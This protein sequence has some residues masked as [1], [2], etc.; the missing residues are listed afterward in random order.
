MAAR[1]VHSEGLGLKH[2]EGRNPLMSVS[3]S[4]SERASTSP[5]GHDKTTTMC[6]GQVRDTG[7]ALG[8]PL[9]QESHKG[10]RATTSRFPQAVGN[11]GTGGRVPRKQ[12]KLLRLN[13]TGRWSTV[14]CRT[15]R[16][17]PTNT[18][19]TPLTR[20]SRTLDKTPPNTPATPSHNE[21]QRGIRWRHGRTA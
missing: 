8:S 14:R 2:S 13:E 21:A 10:R 6:R 12:R 9:Q 1:V 7:G 11:T 20:Q 16:S 17:L 5:A 4:K 3:F 19:L 15:A 18:S